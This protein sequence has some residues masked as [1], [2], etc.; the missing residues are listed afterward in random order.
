MTDLG[1]GGDYGEPA[2]PASSARNIFR[3]RRPGSIAFSR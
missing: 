3:Y 1:A 2:D